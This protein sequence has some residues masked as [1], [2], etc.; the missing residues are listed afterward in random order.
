MCIRDR[1]LRIID[2]PNP[3]WVITVIP[4]Y[5]CPSDPELNNDLQNVGGGILMSRSNY[6][7]NGGSFEWSFVPGENVNLGFG[8]SVLN[9]QAEGRL[10]HDGVLTRTVNQGHDGVRLADIFDGTSN[11]FYCGETIKFGLQWDPTTFGGV[12]GAN[13]ARTLT[14]VRTGH[15]EFNP[16]PD[17]NETGP[18]ILRNSYSSFHS[19]G[20]NFVFVDGSTRFIAQSIDHNQLGFRDSQDMGILRGLYQRLFSRNDGQPIGDSF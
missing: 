19:G 12:A 8:N 11:T 18:E 5:L 17:L 2:L 15:G 3:D 14:Q 10:R 16:N 13:A 7:G 6:V 1:D 4:F 20:A 9:N